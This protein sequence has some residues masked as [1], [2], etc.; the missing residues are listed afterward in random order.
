MVRRANQREHLRRV[1]ERRRAA[2]R[3]EADRNSAR[4]VIAASVLAGVSAVIVSFITGLGSSVQGFVTDVLTDERKPAAAAPP[5]TK[6]A[7]PLKG[8]A[9]PEEGGTFLVS[10]QRVTSPEDRAEVIHGTETPGEWERLLRKI[11]VFRVSGTVDDKEYTDFW[12]ADESGQ[13]RLLFS[14]EERK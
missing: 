11:T 8:V 7:V 4:T 5:H 6:P 14:R 12:G 10:E 1:S 2:G 9:I 13:G 3:P